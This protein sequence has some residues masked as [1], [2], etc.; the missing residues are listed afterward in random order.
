MLNITFR[1]SPLIK[2]G[3][4]LEIACPN[5]SAKKHTYLVG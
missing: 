2:S 5:N 1:K 4:L 3:N